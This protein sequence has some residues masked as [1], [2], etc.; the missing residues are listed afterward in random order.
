MHLLLTDELACP[1]CGPAFPL[2]LLA[3][4]VR[5]RQVYSGSLGCPNCRERYPIH[6]GFGDLRPEPRSAGGEPS[7]LPEPDEEEV[8]IAG[9]LMGVTAE[10]SRPML[11]GRAARFAPGLARLLPALSFTVVSPSAAGWSERAGID[12]IQAGDRLPL[13]DWNVRGVLFDGP[14]PDTVVDEAIRVLAPAHRIAV[15]APDDAVR[16][17]LLMRGLKVATPTEGVLVASRGEAT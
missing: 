8:R 13:R 14:V 17:R 7:P 4:D 16:T 5:D 3:D 12:R 6:D 10:G 9:A 11:W 1:R 2:I 15:V